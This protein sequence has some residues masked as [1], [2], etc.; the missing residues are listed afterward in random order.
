MVEL[1]V[2][3]GHGLVERHGLGLL[4]E[5]LARLGGVDEV[6]ADAR[7]IERT[8]EVVGRGRA[9]GER[10]GD[11]LDGAGRRRDEA[12]PPRSGRL[13]AAHRLDRRRQ[14]LLAA[15]VAQRGVGAQALVDRREV[16]RAPELGTQL[17]ELLVE[18]L[19]QGQARVV[20]VLGGSLRRRRDAD[21]RAVHVVAARQPR[22]APGS[23]L[24]EP[25]GSA[26]DVEELAVAA[27]GRDHVVVKDPVLVR[28]ESL[29]Q[30]RRPPGADHS[31]S[32]QRA[33]CRS[34][35]GRS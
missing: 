17:G 11:R 24:I 10:L 5:A 4:T 7:P 23:R 8:R 6:R 20:K 18:L 2:V 30:T 12:E 3:T 1:E 15:L 32:G 26:S 19:E 9:V 14:D 33:R 29:G 16:A 22:Q 27:D 34:G 13:G 21:H 31:D 35:R 28:R 25:A